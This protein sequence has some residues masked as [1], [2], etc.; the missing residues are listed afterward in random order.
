MHK[1]DFFNLPN[2]KQ[3]WKWYETVL[4]AAVQLLKKPSIC[5]LG[6][7]LLFFLIALIFKAPGLDET[8]AS[9]WKR[10]P[11]PSEKWRVK[12]LSWPD[13]GVHALIPAERRDDG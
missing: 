11:G 12:S 13:V 7:I 10:L 2:Y 1:T 6:V 5:L 8:E 3:C 9:A 4:M